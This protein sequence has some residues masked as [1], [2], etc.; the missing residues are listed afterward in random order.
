MAGSIKV[1]VSYYT[2]R[3]KFTSWIATELRLNVPLPFWSCLMHFLLLLWPPIKTPEQK[4]SNRHFSAKEFRQHTERQQMPSAVTSLDFLDSSTKV[5]MKEGWEKRKK[6]DK[7]GASEHCM[8]FA[9][10]RMIACCVNQLWWDE[11]PFPG[12]K[13]GTSRPCQLQLWTFE[14]QSVV[15]TNGTNHLHRM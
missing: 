5:E 13:Y 10:K 2:Y 1:M 9:Y 12:R 15:Y 8:K 14:D 11:I 6:K 3:K 7:R 4:N